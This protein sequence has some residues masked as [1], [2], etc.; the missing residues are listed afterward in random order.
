MSIAC[1]DLQHIFTST[2]LYLYTYIHL[3]SRSEARPIH[4]TNWAFLFKKRLEYDQKV[5]GK[6]PPFEN[7]LRGEKEEARTGGVKLKQGHKRSHATQLAW[8]HFV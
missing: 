2:F 8:I 4:Y 5:I 7:F 6:L 1:L 3:Q